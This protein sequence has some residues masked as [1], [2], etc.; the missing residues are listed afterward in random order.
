MIAKYW[1]FNLAK[2]K[3]LPSQKILYKS[4]KSRSFKSNRLIDKINFPE[5]FFYN[6]YFSAFYV[7]SY[8]EQR[9]SKHII[10]FTK[11]YIFIIY[12]PTLMYFLL[13][14]FLS[15]TFTKRDLLS[16]KEQYL[17]GC[18]ESLFWLIT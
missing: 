8:I 18:W 5:V 6:F 13:H 7:P 12:L 9:K 11:L 3:L 1:L 17:I 4:H 14:Y 2:N 10:F 16:I 15:N